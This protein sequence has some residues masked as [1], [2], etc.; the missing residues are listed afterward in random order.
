MSDYEADVEEVEERAVNGDAPRTISELL[1]KRAAVTAVP[2]EKSDAFRAEI[3]SIRMGRAIRDLRKQREM[4]QSRLAEL[5]DS[6]QP[7]IARMEGGVSMPNIGTLHKVAQALNVHLMVAFVSDDQ[8]TS[9]PALQKLRDAG[10][11]VTD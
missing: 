1:T 11:V 6:K 4:T 8:M 10:S 3:Y 7:N 2:L 5:V 9:D